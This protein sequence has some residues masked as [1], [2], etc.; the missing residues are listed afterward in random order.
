[1]YS[2]IVV[3]NAPS[4]G[5]YYGSAVAGP[6]FKEIADKVYATDLDIHPAEILYAENQQLIPQTKAGSRHELLYV[7]NQLG[8]NL[9]AQSNQPWVTQQSGDSRQLVDKNVVEATGIVPDVK[10][11]GLR[12]ALYLLESCGLQVSVAGAGAVLSQSI[13]P[14]AVIQ[15]GT[16]ISIVLSL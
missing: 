10:G 14:G 16:N 7:C 13:N 12:D 2:C 3:V 4:K 8:I 6:V 9:Q 1:M 11:M 5:V 15:K